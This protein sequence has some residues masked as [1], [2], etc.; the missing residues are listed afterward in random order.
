MLKCIC[1]NLLFKGRKFQN[2]YQIKSLGVTHVHLLP[3][4]DFRSI[5]ETK[6]EENDY[7]WGYDPENYNV[8][9]GSY[10]TDPYDGATRIKEFKHMVQALHKNGLRVVYLL[11]MAI[12]NQEKNWAISITW[13]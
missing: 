10:A 3:G 13:R 8:P 4:F 1:L 7:N 11:P 2:N 9:E 6:P 5:D 12:P